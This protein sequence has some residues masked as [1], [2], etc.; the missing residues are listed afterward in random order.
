MI[1]PILVHNLPV[2]DRTPVDYNTQLINDMI[3][4]GIT[5]PKT[6]NYDGVI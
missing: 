1:Y 3:K 4:S 2:E 6:I 5:P